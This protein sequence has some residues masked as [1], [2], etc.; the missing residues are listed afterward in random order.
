MLAGYQQADKELLITKMQPV[1][2]K[3]KAAKLWMQS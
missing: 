2:V 1:S 3:S